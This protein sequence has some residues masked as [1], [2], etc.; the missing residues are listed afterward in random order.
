MHQVPRN[1]DDI[2]SVV[3]QL[4]ELGKKLETSKEAAMVHYMHV[5]IV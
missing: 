2:R 5:Q 3:E 4:N 1:V